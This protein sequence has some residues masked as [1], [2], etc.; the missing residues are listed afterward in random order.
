MLL[1]DR[2]RG[3]WEVNELVDV[4]DIVM[5]YGFNATAYQILNPGIEHWVMEDGEA[6]V[7]FVRCGNRWVVAGGPVCERGRLGDVV[8]AFERAAREAGAKVCF[9]CAAER[10][11]GLLGGR[12]DH[13]VIAIGAEPVWRPEE[14]AEVVARHAGIGSQI[15]R[16]ERK[17]VRVVR[18][19]DLDGGRRG[20]IEGV[21]E[22][23]LGARPMP[24]LGFLTGSS[25][26]GAG[27]RDR[28]LF[29]A[30]RER[31]VVA[32]LLASPIPLRNGWLAEQ[33][34]RRREA[35]N[36]T[37]ELLIDAS[38]RCMAE[39][40][41]D[42]VTLGLVAL[43]EHAQERM[44]ENPGWVRLVLGWARAHGRRFY[45]FD[46]LEMFRQ[47]LAPA[48]W[49]PVYAI[50]NEGNFSVGTMVGILRA[51]TEGR[52]VRVVAGALGQAVKREARWLV[53]S[54]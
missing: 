36:G 6:A 29:V 40:G 1:R 34:V 37:A 46:G 28:M 41:S 53:G 23:W 12:S 27:V 42:Y 10:L 18:W 26:L 2:M 39:S 35:P 7:G 48:A 49:E 17:G 14:W 33:I 47:K 54:V 3:L 5:K 38:M 21:L 8:E 30:E 51:F 20:E 50:S 19:E 44:R 52:P 13:A 32:Y 9:V 31:K 4:R 22:A 45:H 25:A 24:K 43:A 15:R 16:A 11:R